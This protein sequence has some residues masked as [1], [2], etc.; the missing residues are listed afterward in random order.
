MENKKQREAKKGRNICS[1]SESEVTGS[2]MTFSFSCCFPFYPRGNVFS[3]QASSF[4]FLLSVKTFSAR[5]VP[6]PSEQ[7]QLSDATG[8]SCLDRLH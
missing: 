3:E 5:S 2:V 7:T 4:L 6:G 8:L 1:Y